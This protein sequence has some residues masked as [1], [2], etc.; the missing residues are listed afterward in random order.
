MVSGSESGGDYAART[1]EV[2][3]LLKGRQGG[4]APDLRLS[5]GRSPRS[6]RRVHVRDAARRVEDNE[7]RKEEAN[8]RETR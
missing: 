6:L 4:Y 2:G 5:V 8:C 3:A 1:D 7:D